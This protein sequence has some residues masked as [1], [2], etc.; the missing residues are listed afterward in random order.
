VLSNSGGM[1]KHLK[2]VGGAEQLSNKTRSDHT[3]HYDESDFCANVR[4]NCAKSQP[5]FTES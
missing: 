3:T 1:V 2:V 4:E 5:V